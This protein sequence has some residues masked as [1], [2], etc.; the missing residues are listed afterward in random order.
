MKTIAQALSITLL[1]TAGTSAY[2]QSLKTP[3]EENMADYL[4]MNR[5]VVAC[6][7]LGL[8]TTAVASG[9]ADMD[10]VNPDKIDDVAKRGLSFLDDR[11]AT[12][13]KPDTLEDAA[14]LSALHYLFNNK[15]LLTEV[16]VAVQGATPGHEARFKANVVTNARC[17]SVNP[18]FYFGDIRD[19]ILESYR[20]H[21]H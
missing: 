21:F 11:V 13:G 7:V 9:F 20:L 18:E 3:T 19:G 12:S 16:A 4:S 15:S 10:E 1:L 8:A 14:K 2:A 5:A 17:A 6:A